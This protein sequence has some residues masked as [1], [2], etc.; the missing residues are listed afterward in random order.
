[1]LTIEENKFSHWE[2]L[3]N[4]LSEE[5]PE[6]DPTFQRWLKEDIENR[7]LYLTLKGKR[8]EST[9]HFDK[10]QAFDNI[11][12]I[13]GLNIRKKELF[14]QKSWFVYVAS[15]LLI[16]SV[17]VTGYF[18]FIHED[19]P[20]SVIFAEVK[21]NIYDPGTKKAYLLSS[22]GEMLDL[23]ETFEI[24]KNDGTI[25]T[26][27]SK[28]VVHFHQSKSPEKKTE[29]H[30]LYVP[31]G[32]EYELLLVD[33]SKVYLNSE[34]KLIFPGRFDGDIRRVE[35][36]GEAYFEIKKD[37]RPFIVQT[38]E[39]E[40]EVLGTTFNVNAYRDNASVLTTL[41]E[42]SVQIHVPDNPETYLLMPDNNFSINKLT[43]KISIRN[44]NT[45]V[46][47][48]WVKGEFVFRNQSLNDIFVQL[49]RWY[50]FK[51]EYENPA[52]RNMRFTGSAKKTRPLNYLLEQI[53]YVTDIKYRDEGDKIILY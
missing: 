33:S 51:I 19:I 24:R 48:A 38:A 7:K 5:I 14:Y 3:L 25:I 43:N 29:H 31:K 6:K 4:V 34:T 50:D 45:E 26:N 39:M 2:L 49:A 10:D 12:D 30:T 27:K 32:G 42:G 9:L 44:V 21:K 8:K 17:S 15:I 53:Q 16:V 35:L 18:A 52:V 41:V 47:T 46:Y 28:G 11:S 36:I 1:M 22:Q 20:V 40:I 23:S 13:L 37:S